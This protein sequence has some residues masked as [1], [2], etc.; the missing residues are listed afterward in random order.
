MMADIETNTLCVMWACV[1]IFG[2][3]GSVVI[4]GRK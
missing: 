2:L 3:I 1:V 4:R